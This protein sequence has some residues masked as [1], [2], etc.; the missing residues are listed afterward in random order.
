MASPTSNIYFYF[1]QTKKDKYDTLTWELVCV[2]LII[3]NILSSKT[4]IYLKE[5][6]IIN[7]SNY[8]NTVF[9]AVAI[10][11]SFGNDDA[12][13]DRGNKNTNKT[14]EGIVSIHL[15]DC[16]DDCSKPD[17][18]GLVVSFESTAN[19]QGTT[20]DDGLPGA[21]APAIDSEFG[22]DNINENV[23]TGDDNDGD[24]D[25]NNDTT[26]MSGNNNEENSEGEDLVPK[27]NTNSTNNPA[28]GDPAQM[29]LLAVTDDDDDN[30]SGDYDEF[31]S[32]YDLNDDGVFDNDN[33]DN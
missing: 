10:I 4:R 18:D 9:K 1:D 8:P 16:G 14:P 2:C 28:D 25:N 17:N 11:T 29:S 23:E 24:D 26:I 30:D 6:Y 12:G 3:N 19:D 5:Q 7:Q 31:R 15:S 13:R 33:T 22:N 32:D 20:D 27:N 21:E